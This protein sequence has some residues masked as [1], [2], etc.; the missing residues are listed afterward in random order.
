MQMQ[1]MMKSMKKKGGLK[2]MMAAI[3]GGG[4][5]IPG[6]MDPGKGG[7]FPF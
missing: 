2:N 1:K 7:K 4:N 6:M 5:H 3:Q